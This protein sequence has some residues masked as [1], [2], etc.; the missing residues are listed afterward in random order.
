MNTQRKR[1]VKAKAWGLAATGAL[2]ALATGCGGGASSPAPQ[3][4]SAPPATTNTAGNTSGSA[5]TSAAAE[6]YKGKTLTVIV[7]YGPGGGYDQW[8]RLLAPYLQKY[9]GVA[10]VDVQNVTGGAGLVGTNQIYSAKPDGLTI[11]DTNAGGDVFDQISKAPGTNFDVSKFSWIGRPDDD[12]HII[13]VHPNGQYQSFADLLK[14]KQPVKALAT[15]KGSSDYNSAVITFNAFNIPFQMVAAFS[16]SKDEKAA[17]LRGNGDTCSLSASDI[18]QISDKAKVVVLQSTRAFDKLP[19]VPT[20]IDVAKQAGLSQD[21]IAGLTAMAN[22]MDMGHAFFAPPGVPADRL[23][24]LREAFQKS[25]QDPSFQAEATKAGLYLGYASGQD[26]EQMTKD[27]LSNQSLL[28][29]LL[30]D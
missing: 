11:G 24:A 7:P 19:G 17:F 20:I 5:S 28:Q 12:P 15:G 4:T 3:N 10:K 14:A 18:K 25:L 6:F 29:P 8:A 30:K 2:L 22:V 21:K 27:A 23:A 13:A 16:G 26:L 9:L 1:K